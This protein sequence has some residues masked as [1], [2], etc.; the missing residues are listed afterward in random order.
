MKIILQLFIIVTLT[1]LI[2]ERTKANG[3]LEIFDISLDQTDSQRFLALPFAFYTESTK[4]SYGG[5]AV[6]RN[7]GQS[8][9]NLVGGGYHSTN[10]S[11]GTVVGLYN[12]SPKF[13]KKYI[14]FDA[15]YYS[16]KGAEDF[17]YYD[18][19][20]VSLNSNQHESVG[21]VDG[22]S[23]FQS[24]II[25]MTY[26]APINEKSKSEKVVE[27]SKTPKNRSYD[28][29]NLN[30][31][32]EG[33]IELELSR[34]YDK[35]SMVSKQDG[36]FGGYSIGGKIKLEYDNRDFP[37]SPSLGS[38]SFVEVSRDWGSHDRSSYT[39]LEFDHSQYL[40]LANFSFTRQQTIAL[41]FYYSNILDW[42][43]DNKPAWFAQSNLGG[44]KK[45]RGYQYSRF[46]GKSALYG[47][48]EYRLTPKSNIFKKIPLI[49]KIDIP[50]WQVVA[51]IEVGRVTDTVDLKEYLTD[52]KYSYGLGVRALIEGI[53]V[54]AGMSMSE[55]SSLFRIMVNQT[56]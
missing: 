16:M 40:P 6:S 22:V 32:R 5:A 19:N 14:Y 54:R 46:F 53:V 39:K 7:Y 34:F 41:N 17:M 2:S 50:W 25:S 18:T 13:L 36:A 33:R 26:V 28:E 9:L 8:G 43:E 15:Q 24:S 55:E 1:L 35:V 47:S 38:K 31:L 23:R 4:F 37:G 56:F 20:K 3:L 10:D 49:K 44:L 21:R 30:S 27:N 11:Y 42:D 29:L 52:P 51:S 12:Y 48:A 45:L